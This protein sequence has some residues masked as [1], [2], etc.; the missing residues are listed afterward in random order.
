[1]AQDDEQRRLLLAKYDEA[2]RECC[3]RGCE[4]VLASFEKACA[5][6]FAVVNCPLLKL[7][8]ELAS[9]TDV[10]ETYYYLERLRIRWERPV[11]PNWAKLRPQAEVELLGTHQ[12]LDQLH[13]AALSLDGTGLKGYGECTVTLREEMIAHRASCF[14]G[15]SA[16]IYDSNRTFSGRVQSDWSER[17]KLCVAK[18][19]GRLAANMSESD[20][21]ALVL[22]N[23]ATKL[24]DE[25]VEIQIFG[26]MT[27]LTIQSVGIDPATLKPHDKVLWEAVKEKL[28]TNEVL[29]FEN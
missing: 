2:Q 1:M 27:A 13:Y 22:S 29:V 3:E 7:H 25:F 18:V 24:Q 11:G 10:F 6:S 4:N 20:F 17:A 26:P 14:E 23:G 28:Q 8:R 19:A 12:H 16:L 21:G 5:K 9:G 15:N